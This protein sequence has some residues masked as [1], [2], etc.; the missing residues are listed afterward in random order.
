MAQIKTISVAEL[1]DL[2]N[3]KAKVRVVDVRSHTEYKEKHIPIAEHFP[4]DKIE[5]GEFTAKGD[6]IIVTACGSGGGRSERSAKMIADRFNIEAYYLDGGTFGWFREMEL[7]QVTKDSLF[8]KF[9]KI[10]HLPT[11]SESDKLKKASLLI[12]ALPFA[13]AGIT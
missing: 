12:M 2:I 6:E 11:D 9:I 8:Q 1:Q 7:R 5:S 4:V 3:A 13:V 10:G